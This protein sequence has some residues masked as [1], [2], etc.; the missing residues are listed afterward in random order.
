MALRDTLK[1]AI[2]LSHMFSYLNNALKLRY[3]SI[4]PLVLIDFESAKKLAENPKFH[5][6][7]KYI[8]ITYHFIKEAVKET[9]IRL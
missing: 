6:K 7:T 8:N 1:D 4:M 9:M 2:Y 5:R 3:V